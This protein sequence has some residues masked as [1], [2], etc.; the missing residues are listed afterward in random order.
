MATRQGRIRAFVDE[1]CRWLADR[2]LEFFA[3]IALARVSFR[4]YAS[5]AMARGR[6]TNWPDVSK[7]R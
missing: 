3:K 1:V 4:L 6:T 7:S 5:G 2:P